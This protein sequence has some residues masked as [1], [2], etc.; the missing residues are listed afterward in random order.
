[1]GGYWHIK[2]THRMTRHFV[3]LFTWLDARITESNIRLNL[4]FLTACISNK[5]KVC[6]TPK[7]EDIVWNKK[8]NYF[9]K[10]SALAYFNI[11][12]V[13]SWHL[14]NRSKS[15]LNIKIYLWKNPIAKSMPLHK[16]TN[17]H[18]P[19]SVH[20]ISIQCDE[21]KLVLWPQTSHLSDMIQ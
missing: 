6:K 21:L 2:H 19:Y 4:P 7:A 14:E 1:M 15:L 13:Y 18:F 3:T 17:A 5:T 16:Y 9:M 11:L 8:V 10:I 20:Y 12:N